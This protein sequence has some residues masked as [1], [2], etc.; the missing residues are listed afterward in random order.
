MVSFLAERFR[1][2]GPSIYALQRTITV[3]GSPEGVATGAGSVWVANAGDGT[4]AR[5]DP[6]TVRVAKTISVG[7]SAGGVAVSPEGIWVTVT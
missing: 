1:S 6:L 3:G 4:V 2:S 5:I 7:G